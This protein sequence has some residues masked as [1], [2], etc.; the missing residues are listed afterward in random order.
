[1]NGDAAGSNRGELS[2]VWLA[3]RVATAIVLALVALIA[4]IAALNGLFMPS[5]MEL[6]EWFMRSGAITAIFAFSAQTQAS[7]VIEL[8]SPRGLSSTGINGL[9]KLF[10]RPLNWIN[11]LIFCVAIAGSVIWGYGD[12]LI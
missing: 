2:T 8:L 9:R 7:A 4:P 11:G 12:L 6:A 1:M 5:S 10:I 3:V